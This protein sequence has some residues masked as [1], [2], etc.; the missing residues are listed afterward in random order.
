MIG[1]TTTDIQVIY[2][3]NIQVT[4]GRKIQRTTHV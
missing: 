2:T 3:T 1:L 4:E